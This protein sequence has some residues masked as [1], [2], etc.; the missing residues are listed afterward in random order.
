MVRFNKRGCCPLLVVL[1]FLLLATP[2]LAQDAPVT[3]DEVNEVARDLY[4][5]VCEN[6]PLDV[7][8][9]QAC[10]AV[11]LHVHEQ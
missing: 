1:G 9:T 6:T 4:C 5:P 11:A 10:A 3:D 7:C 2:A 8:P